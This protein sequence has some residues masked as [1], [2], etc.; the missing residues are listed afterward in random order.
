M[1]V[2]AGHPPQ[3]GC[4]EV[5]RASVAPPDV[6]LSLIWPDL[7]LWK[8]QFGLRDGQ[9]H[10]LAGLGLTSLL[11]Y[12]REV[13]LQD[14]VILRERFPNSPVWN[15]PVFQHKAYERFAARVRDATGPSGEGERP[16]RLALLTQ[17]MPELAD[18]LRSVDTRIETKSNE[19]LGRH[20]RTHAAA[21]AAA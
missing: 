3:M 10:D 7:D 15:H 12:L 20:R 4:F 6:L 11:F 1:R 18:Y 16:T 9:I 17:A 19:L 5:R 21:A 8:D 14:S 2:M 13:I